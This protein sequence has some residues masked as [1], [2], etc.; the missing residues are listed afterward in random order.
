MTPATL[1]HAAPASA[2]RPSAGPPPSAAFP[3][4]LAT[5][6]LALAAGLALPGA[7]RAVPVGETGAPPQLAPW[8]DWVL[9]GEEHYR[10]PDLDGEY[11]AGNCVLPLKLRIDLTDRGGTFRGTWDVRG[12]RRRVRLPGDPKAWPREVRDTAGFFGG[13]VPVG[14]GP[15]GGPEAELGE[16]VHEISGEWSWTQ[17]PETVTVPLGPFPL[18]TVDG[19]PLEFP[20]TDLAWDRGVARIWLRDPGASPAPPTP[21]PGGPAA[22]EPGLIDVRVTRLVV[23]D[24]PLAVTTRLRVTVSGEPR[25]EL[26]PGLLLP[27]TLPVAITSPLPARL[28]AEGLRLQARPGS[29]EIFIEGRLADG[30]GTTPAKPPAEAASRGTLAPPAAAAAGGPSG[31]AF[32]GGL[33]AIRLGPVSGLFGQEYWAFQA[34]PSLRQVEVEGGM[35]VDASQADIPWQNLPVYAL[36]EGDSLTVTTLRRGDPDPGPN[37]LNLRRDCWLDYSG[38]GLSCRD[39][40][41]GQMR[42]DWRLT[43]DHPFE[44]GQATLN[45]EPQVITW[46]KNS[47]GEDA[48]G[49]QL[50]QGS[51]DLA[52]DVR[53]PDFRGEFPASGWDQDLQT[54]IQTVN[55]P[56]G[57]KLL[58]VSG[59]DATDEAGLPA[60]WRDRWTTLDLFIVLVMVFA[61]W[62]LYGLPLAALCAVTMALSYQEFMCPRL[63]YLHL[64]AATAILRVLPPS[65]KAR[66]AVSLW[67]IAAGLT[68][69][70]TC[71]PF[72]LLQARWAGYPQLEPTVTP[73]G[74]PSL[75][76]G[77][78]AQS[79]QVT[80]YESDDYEDAVT[81]YAPE[82][83]FDRKAEVAQAPRQSARLQRGRADISRPAPAALPA[84]ELGRNA[85]SNSM[86]SVQT[87]AQVQN[88]FPRPSWNWRVI[89]LDYNGQAARDQTASLTLTGP[90]FNRSLGVLR[91]LLAVWFSLA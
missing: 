11:E 30:P 15:Q 13:R 70:L 90:G 88:S 89:R 57:W 8:A 59:A 42:R 64:L 22:P 29:W 25:E 1:P 16:G 55:L 77:G 45:G 71:V 19:R 44:I 35:Q 79:P 39:R 62:K 48:P 72:V 10:C 67:R 54:G 52:A 20:E 76:L 82:P 43:A 9:F 56:P 14:T 78:A 87:D 74:M 51:V 47:E 6:L 68:L 80:L 91:L 32:T 17:L 12:G 37:L 31:D 21:A 85:F 61:T 38:R 23:D 26:V 3:L 69:A 33:P 4:T 28:T 75:V 81:S 5:C 73:A 34:T 49:L 2:P 7:A 58:R 66:A 83:V 53:I 41:S 86:Q 24:L 46:Q 40:L 27:G 65:G 60:A 36:D 63:V 18:V 84:A 50:R